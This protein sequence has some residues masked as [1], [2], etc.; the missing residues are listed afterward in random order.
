[1]ADSSF[2]QGSTTTTTEGMS[3][4][5]QS[6]NN[7]R[8]DPAGYVQNQTSAVVKVVGT[9][10]D[11]INGLFGIV[12]SYNLERQRYLVHMTSSQST[13]AFRKENLTRATMMEGYHAQWQ[14]LKN[15]PRV[16]QKLTHYLA[17]WRQAVAPMQLSHVVVAT[18]ITIGLLI[19]LSGV[20]KTIMAITLVITVLLIAGQDVL[21]KKPLQHI[22]SNFPN[23]AQTAM[24]K[25]LPFL[26]GKI[27]AR[28]AAGI[29]V[30]LIALCIQSLFFTTPSV[31]KRIKIPKKAPPV[32]TVPGDMTTTPAGFAPMD[33]D[34]VKKYYVLGFEDATNGK[35]NGASF[36]TRE[37]FLSSLSKSMAP[38]Q[39]KPVS[40][41]SDSNDNLEALRVES[42]STGNDQS[43]EKFP[44]EKSPKK[45]RKKKKKATND[46]KDPKNKVMSITN[47]ASIFYVYKSAQ[48]LGTCPH[49]GIWGF[50]QLSANI[51][52]AVPLW[53]KVLIF[54]SLY[55]VVRII[56]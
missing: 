2:T 24:E 3:A 32:A 54:L 25:H 48:E 44:D 10:R 49:T 41:Q 31:P 21:E 33:Y 40:S 9:A 51:H 38:P 30:L 15:D 50:A 55:N 36:P 39:D 16:R 7:D 1:M 4:F 47:A 34:M 42:N 52:Q 18:L 27:S 35:D 46:E 23:R 29:M 12:V 53:R 14:Q 22:V 6:S 13:M 56:F 37:D 19:Y 17:L 20:L 11:D 8:R 28:M 43:E 45:S 26:Q 5:S